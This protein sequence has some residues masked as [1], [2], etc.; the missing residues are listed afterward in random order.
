MSTTVL[1]SRRS[2]RLISHAAAPSFLRLPPA[3]PGEAIGL[4]G[5]S[6]NP[7]HD[8]HVLVTEIAF[9]RLGLTRIWWMVTPGNPLKSHGELE[10][11]EGRI[12]RSR[13]LAKDPRI[14]VTGFEAGWEVA[15]T[16]QTLSLLKRR[17]PHVRFVWLMGADNLGSFHRWQDWRTIAETFPIAIVDRPG[18]TLLPLSSVAARALSQYRIAETNAGKLAFRKPPA[19]AFLHGPR[20]PLSST[21]LREAYRT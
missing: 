7:P 18:S 17:Y 8:G 14:V 11:L 16:A 5:G 15:Y 2:G 10:A 12:N 21:A 6:F 4:F 1:R 9:R 13:T 20:S 19:W 3:R